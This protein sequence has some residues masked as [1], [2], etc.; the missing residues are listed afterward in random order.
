[1]AYSAFI[2]RIKNVRKHSNADRLNVGTCFG[3]DVIV[4]L[5]TKEGEL[6]VY[7]PTDGRLG[8]KY[9]R[10]NNL[11]RIKNE[12]GTTS[13][14]YLEEGK[15]HVSSLKLRGEKSDGL[16][17]PLT[18]LSTFTDIKALREGDIITTLGGILICE[19]YIPK[20]SAPKIVTS[21]K[22]GK[23]KL[24]PKSLITFPMFEEHIDTAQLAYNQNAFREG[25]VCSITLKMHGTSARTAYSIK[26][27][28]KVI[29]WPV[30]PVYKVLRAFGW[31]DVD[32][33]WDY[34]SG[35]RR[36][37]LKNFENGFY[38]N[39]SFRKT[40]HDFFVGK[41]HKGEEIFYEIVGWV[42]ESTSIMPECANSKT[43][44][45]EFIKTWGA[46][47]RFTYGCENGQ[48]DIYVYRMNIIN[49]DGDTIEYS[50]AQIKMRCEQMGVKT[51]PEFDR[52]IF[53]TWEDLN[54]KVSS[55]LEG[56]DP[57]GKTH[58]K[59]GVVVRIENRTNFAVYKAK[60]FNF[61]VLEGI[62]KA[63][64]VLDMEEGTVE[65]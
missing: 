12:D 53:T 32:T 46:T 3:N 18:S 41:L 25:D 26:K 9:A 11:I 42:N 10:A 56:A 16:F 50:P 45:K 62:I 15:L 49:E 14:G 37:T 51:V 61:K 30:Y 59:E 6:G 55:Y 4:S 40:Y 20:G 44:D 64:N 35:T 22:K 28:L 34:V 23:K 39:D 24:K 36:T 52:F 63:D 33:S 31:K 58:I 57:I 60:S 27:T 65:E 48:N 7:F 38:G 29:P 54:S 1:V 21:D 2:T 8:D 19:K 13:G 5:E 17:M 43:K 47:T